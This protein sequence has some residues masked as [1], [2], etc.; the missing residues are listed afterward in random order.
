MINQSHSKYVLTI[1][2]LLPQHEYNL[3]KIDV[4]FD[5]SVVFYRIKN[6]LKSHI[7]FKYNKAKLNLLLIFCV[8]H[9][10]AIHE[11]DIV[12]R[13]FDLKDFE[14]FRIPI[15]SYSTTFKLL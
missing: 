15:S 9:A 11:I 6:C 7:A 8:V 4:M 12:M 14:H 3:L 13:K 2:Q 5:V 1:T 10:Y